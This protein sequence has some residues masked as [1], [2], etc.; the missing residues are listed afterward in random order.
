MMVVVGSLVFVGCCVLV[1]V[2]GLR[3]VV[4]GLLFDV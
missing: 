3:C 4:C 1:V 2:C